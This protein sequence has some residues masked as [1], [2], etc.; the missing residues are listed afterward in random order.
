MKIMI[1]TFGTHGDVQPF[2]ALGQGL[3][4][5]GHTVAVCTSASYRPTI[6]ALGL[7]YA[8]MSNTLLD[9]TQAL[10]R[11]G[12][13]AY[14]ALPQ[15]FPAMRAMLEEE[16]QAAQ[17]FAPDLLVYHPKMLGSYHLAEKLGISL[18]MA[19]PLPFYTPTR[20]FPNP[21]L[22][23]LRLGGWA[24]WASF[25]LMGL[26]SAMYRGMTNRFRTATL[27]LPPLRS[28]ANLL[29]TRAGHPIPVLYPY[30]PHLLPV[31]ADFPPHVHVTGTWFLEPTTPWV[32]PAPLA[33]FLEAGPPPVYVGFGSMGGYGGLRRAVIVLE[34][35]KLAGQRGVL[36]R[37]W[38]GLVP[39]TLPETV[40][41]LDEA[42]H[43]WL[44]PQTAAVVHHGGSGTTAAGLRAGRPTI[45]CPYVAD[46]PFWG[47]V[48]AERGLGPPP[49]PQHRF[50][51]ERLAAAIRVAVSDQ[52]MR[53][54]AAALGVQ[55]RAEDGVGP[56]VALLE[57]EQARHRA[58]QRA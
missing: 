2:L 41:A 47:R 36:A 53:E 52:G 12:A 55:I 14:G 56:A 37:G 48:V 34:A 10:L 5:A 15:I 18:A 32:P 13:E 9:L 30:S 4:T 11:G 7:T 22:A 33:T 1:S 23:W 25:R 57:R 17:S 58:S 28:F 19:L 42:P 35:L 38:G 50:T 54:R 44:F 3:H 6:E 21:F 24:N 27:G 20:A 29:V 49:I 39:A 8:P 26:T 43:D 51:A 45:I 46:Q 16:W 31:P 40:F